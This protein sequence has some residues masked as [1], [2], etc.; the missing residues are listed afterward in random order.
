MCLL[1]DIDAIQKFTNVLVF[2]GGGLLNKSG[3]SA[4]IFYIISLDHDLVLVAGWLAGHSWQEINTS[5]ELLTEEVVYLNMGVV[6]NNVDVDGE[7]S[8]GRFHLVSVSLENSSEHVVDVRADRSH[9]C[10]VFPLGEVHLNVDRF[11]LKG[12][13]TREMLEALLELTTGPIDSDDSPVDLNGAVCW[14]LHRVTGTDQLH[15]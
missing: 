9:T 13:F 10:H 5:H 4:D 8:V 6:I 14:D 1:T 2:D 7:M 15:G 11:L 12:Q 3:G